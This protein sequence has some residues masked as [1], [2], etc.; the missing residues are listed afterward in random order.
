MRINAVLALVEMLFVCVMF[1]LTAVVVIELVW[2]I[3]P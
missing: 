2:R 1:S 3:I